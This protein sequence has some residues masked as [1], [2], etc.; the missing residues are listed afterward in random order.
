MPN[1]HLIV[2]SGGSIGNHLRPILTGAGDRI[3]NT[4]YHPRPLGE[5]SDSV[6]WIPF[7]LMES[8]RDLP[9]LLQKLDRTSLKSLILFS[10]PTLSREKVHP[11]L[12]QTLSLLPALEGVRALFDGS[13]PFLGSGIVLS[14]VPALSALKAG[15]Y[16][17]ARI[18]FG[19]LG[20]LLEE[21]S[22]ATDPAPGF[23]TLELV[24]VPGEDTPHIPSPILEQMARNTL[25]GS[26]PDSLSLARWIAS[27]IRTFPGF[28]HGK[29]LR[30]PDG[31]FF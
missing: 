19:G 5:E 1:T 11:P 21:Y 31:P 22:R 18:Y 10:H 16:L 4:H 3:L 20:G 23:L 7:D 12:D 24:H 25:A 30:L 6:C 14:V 8:A 29:T 9:V 28:L 17:K 27:L 26:L 2:G 15:G 13:I